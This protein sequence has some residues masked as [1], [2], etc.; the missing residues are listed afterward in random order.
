[1][2]VFSKFG[3][4][5]D[6][7]EQIFFFWNNLYGYPKRGVGRTVQIYSF[8]DDGNK[9]FNLPANCKP[10]PRI[11]WVIRKYRNIFPDVSATVTISIDPKYYFSLAT[12]RNLSRERDGCTPSAGFYTTDQ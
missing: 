3:F 4:G 1:M 2:D 9:F 12:G 5:L 10:K 6:D 8:G 7:P 11:F